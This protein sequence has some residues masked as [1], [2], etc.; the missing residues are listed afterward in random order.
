[1]LTTADYLNLTGLTLITVGSICAARSAPTVS[2]GPDGSVSL[3]AP[4]VDDEAAKKERIAMHNRQKR[5]PQ[6][7]WLIAFGAIL[8]AAGVL[9]A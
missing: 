8:Q 7:L 5:F 4:G 3:F 2:Y 1:M 9:A 6:F